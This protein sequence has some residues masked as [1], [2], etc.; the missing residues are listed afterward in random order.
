VRRRRK[1]LANPCLCASCCNA[2]PERAAIL[3]KRTAG[4]RSWLRSGAGVTR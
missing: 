4:F 1:R 2:D 3:A